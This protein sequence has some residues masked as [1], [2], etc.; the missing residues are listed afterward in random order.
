MGYLWEKCLREGKN[1]QIFAGSPFGR[2]PRGF[3][4][5]HEQCECL[6]VCFSLVRECVYTGVFIQFLF[7]GGPYRPSV[8]EGGQTAA[9][10]CHRG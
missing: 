5:P 7:Y 4:L 10:Y 2:A 1:K 8:F 3:Y 6:N 9:F